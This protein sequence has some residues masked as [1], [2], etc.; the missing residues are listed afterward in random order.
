MSIGGLGLSSAPPRTNV[1]R[2]LTVMRVRAEQ[3]VKSGAG[4]FIWIAAL[5]LINSLVTIF[6]GNFHFILGLGVTEIVDAFAH[7]AGPAAAIPGLIIN[8]FVGGVFVLF[9]QFG[10]KGQTWA[11]IVGMVLYGLDG[12]LLLLFR[13]I[14]SV[15]FHAYALFMLYRGL[16][17]ISMLRK[18]EQAELLSAVA[19]QPN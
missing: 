17:G 7:G 5:S 15:A 2:D 12:V 6:N 16:T 3:I 9:W 19:I 1:A 8:L 11:F 14:L 13:D 4:W 18:C 10:R